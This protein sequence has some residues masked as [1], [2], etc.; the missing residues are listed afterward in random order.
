MNA[1]YYK[2]WTVV[3]PTPGKWEDTVVPTE[4]WWG[5]HFGIQPH[6]WR[7]LHVFPELSRDHPLIPSLCQSLLLTPLCSELNC[8]IL[9][10]INRWEL[11]LHPPGGLLTPPAPPSGLLA[12]AAA[13]LFPVKLILEWGHPKMNNEI[14]TIPHH[15]LSSCIQEQRAEV[16]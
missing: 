12:Q 3:L 8:K 1:W 16:I 9:G 15:G 7:T 11:L 13:N 14:M 5:N 2:C 10:K 4:E 6:C